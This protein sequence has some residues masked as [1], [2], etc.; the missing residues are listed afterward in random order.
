M[1]QRGSS[2]K[3]L[4]YMGDQTREYLASL[5]TNGHVIQH[6]DVIEANLR[7]ATRHI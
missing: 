5:K 1:A 4:S 3:C 2:W 7:N 6:A